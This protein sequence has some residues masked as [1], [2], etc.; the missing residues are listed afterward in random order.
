MSRKKG[1]YDTSECTLVFTIGSARVTGTALTYT[2]EGKV[3]VH[4]TVI[5]RFVYQEQLDVDRFTKGMLT[6]LMNVVMDLETNAK[7]AVKQNIGKCKFTDP[8]V[9]FAAPWFVS[10][11]RK[12][13]IEKKEAFTVTEESIRELVTS[14]IEDFR[15]M[16]QSRKSPYNLFSSN[17]QVTESKVIRTELNGYT[18][19]KPLGKQANTISVTLYTSLMSQD[20]SDKVTDLILKTFHLDQIIS[21][22]S[23]L[24]SYLA[25]EQFLQPESEYLI[26]EIH[27]EVTDTTIVYDDVIEESASYPVGSN[28]V[29]RNVS[30]KTTTKQE[31]VATRM[32]LMTQGNSDRESKKAESLEDVVYESIG[33][34]VDGLY[35]ALKKAAKGRPVPQTA[36]LLCDPEWEVLY[37]TALKDRS[38]ELF[39]FTDRPFTIISMNGPEVRSNALMKEKSH[40]IPLTLLTGLIH[41]QIG[42]L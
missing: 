22:S 15:S 27:G 38:F 16:I 26:I 41:K 6:A 35:R 21:R 11:T 23:T 1:N 7:K 32:K 42:S 10:Q 3:V 5:E 28:S 2:E 13:T 8:V 14:E 37:T 29:I 25:I 9:V 40:Y 31:D 20:I 34:W 36:F 39:T 24:V 30:K 19:T 18:T 4:H 33:E 12:V 17:S